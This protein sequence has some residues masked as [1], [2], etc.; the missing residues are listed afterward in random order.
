MQDVV[1]V[2]GARTP[3]GTFG[4]ALKTVPVVELGSIVMKAVLKRAGLRPASSDNGW[5]GEEIMGGGR[6]RG[7]P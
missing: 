5:A 7:A 1:I 6:S 3:V 4:S 2:S